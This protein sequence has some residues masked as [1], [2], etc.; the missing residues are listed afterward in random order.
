MLVKYHYDF[1]K[2]ISKNRIPLSPPHSNPVGTICVQL[3]L[4]LPNKTRTLLSVFVQLST[5]ETNCDQLKQTVFEVIYAVICRL[6]A[7]VTTS[8]A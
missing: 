7:L 4:F 3:G 5:F 8:Y 1:N 2:D 6:F